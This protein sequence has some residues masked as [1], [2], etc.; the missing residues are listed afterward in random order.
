VISSFVPSIAPRNNGVRTCDIPDDDISLGVIGVIA[1][2]AGIKS[3]KPKNNLY[4][5]DPEYL[6]VRIRP[7]RC[8][9]T[10]RIILSSANNT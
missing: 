7:T 5:D 9:A 4:Q 6:P 8:S 2:T 10:R 3:R 1:L